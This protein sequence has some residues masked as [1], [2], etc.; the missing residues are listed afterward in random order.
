MD[1][2]SRMLVA[3][4]YKLPDIYALLFAYLCE[5]VGKGNVNISEGVSESFAISAVRESVL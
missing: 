3:D 2:Y 5:L 1:I 4:L